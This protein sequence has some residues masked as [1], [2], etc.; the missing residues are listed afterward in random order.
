MLLQIATATDS[1][2]DSRAS[3]DFAEAYDNVMDHE[4]QGTKVRANTGESSRATEDDAIEP[5]NIDVQVVKNLLKS[6]SSQN[7]IPGPV[8]NLLGMM[9]VRVPRI[10]DDGDPKE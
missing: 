10:D 9:D 6:Y 1:D 2:D 8:G 3:A 7:G 5:M 4:L